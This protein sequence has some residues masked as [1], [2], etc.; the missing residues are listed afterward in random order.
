[1]REVRIKVP[2]GDAGKVVL[3]AE[4]LGLDQLCIHSE[5]LNDSSERVD[6]VSLELATPDAKTL[7]AALLDPE[8]FDASNASVTT[9]AV[10]A[11]VGR[12]AMYAL[13]RPFA[14]PAPD[15]VQ[16]LWQYSHLTVGLVGRAL[17]GATLLGYGMICDKL[18]LMAGGLLFLPLLPVLL[19]LGWATQSR[20]GPLFRHAA[21][22]M[23]SLTLVMLFGGLLASALTGR[24]MQ[25]ADFSE[26]PT[27]CMLS[28]GIGVAGALA[29]GD[30]VGRRELIGL[31]TAS[32]VALVPVWL[33]AALLRSDT[34]HAWSRL[35]SCGGSMLTL[36]SAS[37][38]TYWLLRVWPQR[39]TTR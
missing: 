1:M 17:V 10:R 22:A 24:A 29:T 20:D 31:A 4:R 3:L 25:Y 34:E 2:A 5:Q 14:E 19:A 37:S 13:T 28:F 36:V 30:D 6:V 39:V 21:K 26:L 32:Q 18:L 33:G 23:C 7:V 15:I 27:A 35:A 11:I 16:D 12:H 38:L 8:R 9:R